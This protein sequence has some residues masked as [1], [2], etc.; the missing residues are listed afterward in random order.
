[1]SKAIDI[2]RAHFN[3]MP[4]PK[5]KCLLN[6]REKINTMINAVEAENTKL[7]KLVQQMY[8]LAKACLQ[9]G[10]A[11]G[12]NDDLSYDW[13]LQMIELGIEVPS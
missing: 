13:V 4:V 8:P 3:Q 1:M 12:H 11:L 2:I 10:V 5:A 9:L 7:R 6:E